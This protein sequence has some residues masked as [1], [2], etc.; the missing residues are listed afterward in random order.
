M[1]RKLS[2]KEKRRLE[3]L[4]L[5]GTEE[6]GLSEPQEVPESISEDVRTPEQVI[7][8][9]PSA[10]TRGEEEREV[11]EAAFAP[12]LTKKEK[13]FKQTA[14]RSFKKKKSKFNMTLEV[15]FDLKSPKNQKVF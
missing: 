11:D 8:P 12:K 10:G 5:L 4:G 1:S 3:K 14:T 6:L 15:V 2:K 13:A 7:E 9:E